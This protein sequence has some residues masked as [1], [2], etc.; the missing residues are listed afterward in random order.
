MKFRKSKVALALGIGVGVG[1]GMLF[2]AAG[3]Y[4]QNA[5]TQ[6]QAD[7]KVE[8]TGS[9]IKRVEGEGALPVTV[10]TRAEIDKTGATNA[11]EL[12][13]LISSNNSAGNTSFSNV[14][15][16]TTFSNQTASL[17]GLGGQRTLI[18]ID[19]K[20]MSPTGGAISAAEGVNLSTIPFS[21]IERVEVLKDGA[22]A[23]YGSDAIAGVINFIMR[24]DY[25]GAEAFVQ[26]GT[27]T[28]SGGGDQWIGSG[29][30]GF[31]DLSKDRYN[32]L[33]S[34]SYSRQNSLDGNTRDFAK[35]SYLPW[36]G[37]FG[38]SSNTFPGNITTGGIGV[39]GP[40]VTPNFRDPPILGPGCLYDPSSQNG[41]QI[42]PDDKLWNFM[43][44]GKFQI[45]RDW[46]AYATALYSRDETRFV[47]QPT[48]ISELFSAGNFAP[49]GQI[50]LQ[51]G[52]PFYPH[53]LASAA[54]VDGQPLN[55][56]YRCVECGFRDTTD[57]NENGQITFGVK[58]AW[59]DWDWDASG[60]YSQSKAHERV[61][62]GFVFYSQILPLLNS[63]T[64]NLFGPNTGS[65]LQALQATKYVG[66]TFEGEAKQYGAN[67]KTSGEIFKLPAG[68][69]ALA[70]G[71]EYRRE[72]LDQTPSAALASGDLT[73]YGGNI[74]AVN[75]SR[76]IYAAYAELNVPILK[77]VE[78][79]VAVR[80]DHY[81]D[82]G[83]TTNPK[84]SL[85]W[86]P[87]STFL[88]RTSYGTGFLAPS[89]YELYE[90]HVQS[91][92]ATG[93]K[94]PTRCPTTANASDCAA[95]FAVTQGGNPNL[96]PERSYQV[97]IGGVW[98]PVQGG[99]VSLDYFKLNLSNAISTG[100]STQTILGNLSNFGSYVTRGPVQPQFPN[101]PGPITNIQQTFVN[102]GNVHMEGIDGTFTY[103]T[104]T[105][106]LGNFVFNL[107][108]TYYIRYDG[109]AT[110][111]S[112][113]GGVS[114]A[115]GA[116]GLGII[117]R[118]K[119]YASLTWN[120]GPWSTTVANTFQTSYID[121][122]LDYFYNQRR[123]GSLSLWDLQASYTG[124][125]NLKLTLGVK[126]LFDT[127][128]PVSNV[129]GTFIFGFDSSYYD[130]RARFVYG[131]VS[132][133]F[134]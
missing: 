14:I 49:N 16:A 117:P 35:T 29:T 34:L 119:Q 27:P 57:T 99:S 3:A 130:P 95:Q 41:V 134:K 10:I 120:T 50:L 28:R 18:L 121:F 48:P 128:P 68:M 125:K 6:A 45:N 115:Y 21:A 89:L 37:V 83:S 13:Q 9:N 73:G 93:Q 118:Y 38:F 103:H 113:V 107:N 123:V 111:G 96:G 32:A 81:S 7:I 24:S 26:Y 33:M 12:L 2:A 126:N 101:I 63:G 87:T 15:G 53:D 102:L 109:Q 42:I 5:P 58:G 69:A 90:P 47:I 61:N 31:G 20:R 91:V 100:P 92:S 60:F 23:I 8:V 82:F 22:S 66:T 4:A 71:A 124:F 98:E 54:G 108:G 43:A 79:N 40:C 105:S 25:Q 30:V 52:S 75:Q 133:S 19:G 76:D 86:Q 17:R 39:Q 62:N 64:V 97:T 129:Q 131:S 65:T 67:L 80:Y 51:P 36:I 114:N 72:E 88:M 85:R 44:S 11:M 70:V 1:G 55:V 78:G 77:T 84:V 116:N 112:Y 59:K 94:D 106:W 104:P 127:N 122:G 132:Y 74:G 46:Q 110:D 56:R